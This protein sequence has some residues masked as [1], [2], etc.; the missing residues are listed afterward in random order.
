[1]EE[2]LQKIIAAAG[3]A[4]RREAEVFITTGLVR[5]NGIVVKKLGTKADP[6][7]DEITL[8]GKPVKVQTQFLTVML[9]KPRDYIASVGDPEGRN[10]VTDLVSFYAAR[11]Y[12]VGRLDFQSEG[13]LLMTNDGDLAFHLTHP[14]YQVEKCY[15]V[16]LDKPLQEVDRIKLIAGVLLDGVKTQTIGLQ[17]IETPQRP[18]CVWKVTLREGRNRQIRRM[19]A[20]F[21]YQALRLMRVREGSLSLGTLAVGKSRK[22]TDQEVE[23]LKKEAGEP[24]RKKQGTLENKKIDE[25]I[26]WTKEE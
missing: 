20:L 14:K 11:L 26:S 8:A 17:P 23:M 6:E 21:E 12:P 15:H 18:G 16:W 19:F 13:L 22:L 24:T 25:E 7:K 10:S 3:F 1:M 2:R 9:H 5:V 4:S